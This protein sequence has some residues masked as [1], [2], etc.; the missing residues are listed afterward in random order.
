MIKHAI[1][2]AVGL[3]VLG[4]IIFF[5]ISFT[6]MVPKANADP[7]VLS[8]NALTAM[9]ASGILATVSVT[10][11][12]FLIITD[13]DNMLFSADRKLIEKCWKNAGS[14][15]SVTYRKKIDGGLFAVSIVFH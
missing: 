15:V 10:R 9:K 11:N 4:I 2:A 12:T 3:A 5:L 7:A 6:L 1:A 14:N 8:G 13:S